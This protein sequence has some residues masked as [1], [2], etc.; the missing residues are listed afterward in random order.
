MNRLLGHSRNNKWYVACRRIVCNCGFLLV[1][2]LESVLIRYQWRLNHGVHGIVR[3]TSVIGGTRLTTFNWVPPIANFRIHVITR[4]RPHSPDVRIP[5][6]DKQEITCFKPLSPSFSRT[7]WL[8][9]TYDST[10]S[11]QEPMVMSS[12]WHTG[13]IKVTSERRREGPP[14]PRRFKI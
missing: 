14:P 9:C 6:F 11:R 12:T 10:T 5:K 13:Q 3:F 1:I 2:N 8:V 4:F 7:R